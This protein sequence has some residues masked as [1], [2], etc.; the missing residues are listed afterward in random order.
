ME[1]QIIGMDISQSKDQS[2]IAS[3][4]SGCGQLIEITQ[5][6]PDIQE[7]GLTVFKKCPYCGVKFLK[8]VFTEEF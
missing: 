2:V 6:D 8:H 1:T 7:L 3:F 5:Y 4:C